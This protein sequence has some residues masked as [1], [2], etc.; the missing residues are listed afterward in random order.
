MST[1]STIAHGDNFHFYHKA[2]DEESVYLRLEGTEFE[3]TSKEITVQIPMDVWEVIR[4]HRGIKLDLANKTDDELRKRAEKEVSERLEHY[5]QVKAEGRNATFAAFAGSLILGDIN[6]PRQKQIKNGFQ[7]YRNQRTRQQEIIAR[8]KQHKPSV[9]IDFPTDENNEISLKSDP[10]IQVLKIGD[11][12]LLLIPTTE[13]FEVL[14]ERIA[15]ILQKNGIEA[16]EF[17]D[18]LPEV[19]REL[20][21]EF[22]PNAAKEYESEL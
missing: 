18:T 12:R 2:F 21:R 3:A 20:F 5:E 4:Q 10:P 8:M 17:L 16:R 1:K 13:E 19:R 22:Y 9:K 7:Y 6:T 15:D 14:N 11:D